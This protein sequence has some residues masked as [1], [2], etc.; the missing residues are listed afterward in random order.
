[1]RLS[2][3][4]KSIATPG[5]TPARSVGARSFSYPIPRLSAL[6]SRQIAALTR[7][8][9]VP[10]PL[11]APGA[12]PFRAFPPGGVYPDRPST[13]REPFR[14]M[15]HQD[16]GQQYSFPSLCD[17]PTLRGVEDAPGERI[18]VAQDLAR[19]QPAPAFRQRNICRGG[20]DADEAFEDEAEILPTLRGRGT[21]H[22]FP[23]R[24]S[25]IFSIRTFPHFSNN[26]HGFIEK[27]ER[28]PQP[29]TLSR[30]GKI[31]T[32]RAEGII[33]TGSRSAPFSPCTSP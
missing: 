18:T 30:D 28:L 32:G 1:M 22:V 14:H 4:L 19:V 29:G 21:R 16:R 3:G 33:S 17:A 7:S 24:P 25:W 15:V 5:T 13:Q 26:A 10:A 6:C 12:A 23:H 2:V 31:L 8:P 11:S 9:A 27:P 20:F